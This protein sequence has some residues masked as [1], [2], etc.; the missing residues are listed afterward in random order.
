MKLIDTF[1]MEDNIIKLPGLYALWTVLFISNFVAMLVDSTT[2]AVRNF[3]LFANI[4]SVIYPGVA[5]WN[6]IFGNRLPS[7]LLLIGGPIHQYTYWFLFSY[8][9][10]SS[11]LSGS[12]LGVLNWV[13]LFVVGLFSIDMIIK[14]WYTTINPIKYLE[15]AQGK[16]QEEREVE[17]N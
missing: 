1:K 16:V 11:V 5:S 3:N 4:I 10:G 12:P 8:F 2:G 15:Y 17:S 7:T 9:G 6:N 13:S 14:T